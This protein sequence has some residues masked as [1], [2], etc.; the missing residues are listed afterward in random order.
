MT[1]TTPLPESERQSL[2]SSFVSLLFSKEVIAPLISGIAGI[3]VAAIGI[4]PLFVDR[5]ETNAAS[6]GIPL[7]TIAPYF[8]IEEDL[9]DAWLICDGQD[10]PQDSKLAIDANPAK[11][12]KQVPDLRGRFLRGA[13]NA[14][15]LDLKALSIG[16]NDMLPAHGHSHA[17]AQFGDRT[18]RT[19]DQKGGERRLM[20]WSDGMDSAGID[21]YPLVLDDD[22]NIIAPTTF[23]TSLDTH[24]HGGD[25]RPSFAEVNWIIRIR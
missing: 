22:E 21:D 8:G 12:G 16:G 17:W 15:K 20:T 11:G 24:D 2:I 4:L 5:A 14:A 9:G 7:G 13:D 6:F 25:N 10:L 19:F 1:D 18:W 23:Y 3:V